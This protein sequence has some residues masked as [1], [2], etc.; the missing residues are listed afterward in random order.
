E[1]GSYTVTLTVYNRAGSDTLTRENMITVTSEPVADFSANRTSGPHPLTVQFIDTSTG[2]PT[3]WN[4]TFGNESH[5]TEQNPVHV[6][7]N[8]GRYSV[9]LVASNAAGN[10]TELKEG[11]ITVGLPL[12]ANFTYSTG[13]PGNTAPLTVAFTDR[14]TGD[15]RIWS[16][17]FGDGYVTNEKNPIHT[18]FEPGAY[19]ISLTVTGLSGSD[20]LTKTIVVKSALKA[21]FSANPTMGNDPLTIVL[22]DTSIGEP[23]SRYWVISKGTDVVLLNPGEQK[24][25]YT[26]NEPGLYTVLLHITDKYG[27][28]SDLEKKNYINVLPFPPE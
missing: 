26:L 18:Y 20:T 1:P 16:W 10:S 12:A 19:N 17:R 15:P 25:V 27:S 5:S 24:Q 9:Q 21:D 8:P 23:V 7:P 13:T 22:T 2:G 11:Y 4:W 14:S 6:F 3:S 28:F